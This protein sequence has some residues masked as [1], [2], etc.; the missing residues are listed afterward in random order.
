MKI[1]YI[2]PRANQILEIGADDGRNGLFDLKPYLHSEAF[3][4]L[5]NNVSFQRVHNGGYFIEWECGADLSADTIE[6]H[7]Q[8]LPHTN[9]WSK[10]CYSNNAL[11]T[12]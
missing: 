1:K 12:S 10:P 2:Y 6:A 4:E 9:D 5:R 3:V 8:L 7:W 11:F